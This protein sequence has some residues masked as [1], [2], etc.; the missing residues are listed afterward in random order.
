MATRNALGESHRGRVHTDALGVDAVGEHTNLCAIRVANHSSNPFAKLPRR[1]DGRLV[2]P[3]HG[4]AQI[5]C[6]F[7]Q[8]K[9]TD[10]RGRRDSVEPNAAEAASLLRSFNADG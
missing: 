1:L 5:T 9:L 8:S 2:P 3:G 4:R 7:E 6:P 10:G